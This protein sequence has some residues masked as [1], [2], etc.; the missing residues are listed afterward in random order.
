[1]L[2]FRLLNSLYHQSSS[3]SYLRILL[4]QPHSFMLLSPAKLYIFYLLHQPYPS[5]FHFPLSYPNLAF[6]PSDRLSST[7]LS[8]STSSF[9]LHPTFLHPQNFFFFTQFLHLYFLFGFHP[10]F[11][12]HTTSLLPD[13]HYYSASPPTIT[14]LPFQSLLLHLSSN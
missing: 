14:P 9:F 4:N 8:T 2:H 5:T 7:P 11:C 10:I 13:F 6:S 1:M 3:L 12:L